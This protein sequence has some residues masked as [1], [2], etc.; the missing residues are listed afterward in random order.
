MTSRRRAAVR[1]DSS[2]TGGDVAAMCRRTVAELED[3]IKGQVQ[4]EIHKLTD[5]L[6]RLEEEMKEL[7]DKL[8]GKATM[9]DLKREV[10]QAV[11]KHKA[12]RMVGG[13]SAPNPRAFF[14]DK[15]TNDA[16]ER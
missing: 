10:S 14:E 9:E 13:I 16:I 1:N 15:K 11:D 3:K 7:Q 12:T 5:T 6:R 8:D 4:M 2:D